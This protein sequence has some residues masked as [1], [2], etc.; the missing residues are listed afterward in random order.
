MPEA[1][2]RIDSPSVRP[3]NWSEAKGKRPGPGFQI[4]GG[5]SSATTITDGPVPLSSLVTLPPIN[6]PVKFP[7]ATWPPPMNDGCRIQKP[8]AKANPLISPS[9]NDSSAATQDK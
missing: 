2:E 9:P 4:R 1:L 5:C 6:F 3:V 8:S 7:P